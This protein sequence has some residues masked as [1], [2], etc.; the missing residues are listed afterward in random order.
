[1]GYDSTNMLQN[2]GILL[3]GLVLLII[4]VLLVLCLRWLLN[5][6]EKVRNFFKMIWRK[7]FWNSFI[8]YFLEAFFEL[9]ISSMLNMQA[10]MWNNFS[11]C[12]SSAMAIGTITGLGLSPFAMYK[13]LANRWEKNVLV[14]SASKAKYGA[15]YMNLYLRRKEPLLANP[16]FCARRFL[17]AS[18]AIYLG[19]YGFAQIQVLL[20]LT[21]LVII[22]NGLAEVFIFKYMYFLELFN[23][24]CIVFVGYHLISFTEFVEDPET[25]YLM[26]YSIAGVTVLNVVVNIGALIIK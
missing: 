2:L 14:L 15:L 21:S 18:S 11:E 16:V 5:K 19:F 6:Y 13:F 24:V 25:R 3:V 4:A 12:L 7:I 9:A 17:L 23:E 10:L 26:G 1:M 22:F 8:R 20:F